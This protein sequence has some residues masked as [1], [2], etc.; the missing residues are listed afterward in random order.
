MLVLIDELQLVFWHWQIIISGEDWNI[1][2]SA[3]KINLQILCNM[4][5]MFK[6]DKM[7]ETN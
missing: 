2:F 3:F 7:I 4:S 1:N 5:Q 6:H